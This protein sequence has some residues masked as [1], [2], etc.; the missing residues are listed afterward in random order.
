[1]EWLR[2]GA[3]GGYFEVVLY[4]EIGLLNELLGE[5]EEVV[6]GCEG[7]DLYC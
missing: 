1:V 6:G 4:V 7:C 3:I 5:V 2:R